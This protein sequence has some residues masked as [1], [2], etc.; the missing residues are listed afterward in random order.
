M[1]TATPIARLREFSDRANVSIDELLAFLDSPTGRRIRRTLATGMIVS[2]P[3]VMR[4]PGL[5]RSPIGR[6][7]ELVGGTTLVVR[8]AEIIRDWERDQPSHAR[9][10]VIDVPLTD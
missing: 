10:T 1:P 4:L 5:R 2:V 3:L 9:N 7:V 8:L 6:M